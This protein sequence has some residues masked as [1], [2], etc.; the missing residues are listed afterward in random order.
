[1]SKR[2]YETVSIKDVDIEH[3]VEEFDYRRL[4]VGFDVGKETHYACLMG[5]HQK[6]YYL[7][8]FEA[9][10]EIGRMI[11]LL[12]AL[13]AAEIVCTME[14]TGTYG[15]PLRAQLEH[16]GYEVRQLATSK[17]DQAK[18]LFDDVPSLHDG[19]SAYLVARL[20]VM[21]LDE[22]WKEQSDRD[23]KL[24]T[25][26]KEMRLHDEQLERLTGKMEGELAKW[27]PELTVQLD[28][29]TATLQTLVAEYGSPAEVVAD[30]EGAAETM[31]RASR[32]RLGAERIE[33]VI[34][35]ARGTDGAEPLARE[36]QLLKHLAEQMREASVGVRRCR[37]ELDEI[38]EASGQQAEEGSEIGRLRDFGGTKLASALVARL[39][40]PSEYDS[41]AAYEKAAGLNL[42]VK[43][44]GEHD[45]RPS[46]TKK[47]PGEV[48]KY[49]YLLACRMVKGAGEG[50]PYVRA[51]YQQRLR[52]NG[53]VRLKGL[54]A[55]MRKLIRAI[56]HIGRGAVYDP[57][58]LFDVSRLDLP[59]RN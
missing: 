47:G 29:T 30:P 28:L 50:C 44:S 11:E 51:W 33:A 57:T 10:G 2:P 42:K 32:G 17:C 5:P 27:W 39:G 41:A 56:F 58:Q 21:K 46:I 6:H 31:R 12:E 24:E 43:S 1:M 38:I 16:H 35:S 9:R 4:Q 52:R 7:V 18:E 23:R 45:G 48:R 15:E 54:V 53:G 14:P 34:E 40:A 26:L 20:A 55:V 59:A 37:R 8:H 36:V 19:K 3:L 13:P 49:L 25:I 22:G